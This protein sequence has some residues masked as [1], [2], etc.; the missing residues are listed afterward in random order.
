MAVIEATEQNYDELLK[1]EYVIVDYY[2]EHCGACVALEPVYRE[3]ANDMPGIQFLKINVTHNPSIGKRYQIKGVPTMKFFRDGEIVHE[4]T[5][6]M[7]RETLN[8]HIAAMLY[9]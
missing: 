4:A 6:S 3:A 5:G 2:G 9:E 7:N 8:S 1:E